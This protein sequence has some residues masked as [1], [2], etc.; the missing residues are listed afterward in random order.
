[1][2]H[3]AVHGHFGWQIIVL[4]IVQPFAKNLTRQFCFCVVQLCADFIMKCLSGKRNIV[5]K[6]S[7]SYQITLA[8]D[9]WVT[10]F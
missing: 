2:Q 1:M 3:M 9:D 4:L 6:N 5:K 7:H 10:I 8:I